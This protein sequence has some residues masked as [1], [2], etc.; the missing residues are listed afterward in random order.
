MSKHYVPTL[1]QL[2]SDWLALPRLQQV[3]RSSDDVH[4]LEIPHHLKLG[5]ISRVELYEPRN[6]IRCLCETPRL[7]PC[8]NFGNF[9]NDVGCIVRIIEQYNVDEPYCTLEV[10]R[11]AITMLGSRN[12]RYVC[13]TC[14]KMLAFFYR[15]DDGKEE[16]LLV[17]YK[18]RAA[19][20]DR[21][22]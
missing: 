15:M 1:V 22:L 17:R 2:A 21:T 18:L 20:W 10:V 4:A 3:L 7:L 16:A 14:R 19:G 6:W 12:K 9:V 8:N 5:L 13:T 11:C